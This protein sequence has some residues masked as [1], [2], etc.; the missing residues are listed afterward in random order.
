MNIGRP[1]PG[2]AERRLRPQTLLAPHGQKPF[3]YMQKFGAPDQSR[4]LRF[5]GDRVTY[6]PVT[7]AASDESRRD[8]DRRKDR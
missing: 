8:A 2:S 4:T 3:P 5:G 7:A 1:E 6:H